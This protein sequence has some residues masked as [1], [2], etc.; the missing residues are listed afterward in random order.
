ML[1]HKMLTES[2]YR[3]LQDILK[4]ADHLLLVSSQMMSSLIIFAGAI[5]IPQSKPLLS[6]RVRGFLREPRALETALKD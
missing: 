1:L 3:M 6:N 4:G 2:P 5:E